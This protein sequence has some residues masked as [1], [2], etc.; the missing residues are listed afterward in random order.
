MPRIQPSDLR[1]HFP[2]PAFDE[3]VSLL[4]LVPPSIAVFVRFNEDLI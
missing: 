2:P 4:L 3:H 1:V